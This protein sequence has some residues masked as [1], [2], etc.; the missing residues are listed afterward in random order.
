MRNTITREEYLEAL[1]I[2]DKYNRQLVE[3]DTLDIKN[4]ETVDDFLFKNSMKFKTNRVY[5]I[6]TCENYNKDRH[7]V[8]MD[9]VDRVSFMKSRNAGKKSW[10]ELQSVIN[11]Y[12]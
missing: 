9:Q 10:D 1:E 5:N 7:F 3:F 8:Y 4:R 12:K 2:V 11:D 6:L